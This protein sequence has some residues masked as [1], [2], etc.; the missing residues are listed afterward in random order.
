MSRIRPIP[1]ER[2]GGYNFLQYA[3][4]FNTIHLS[5]QIDASKLVEYRNEKSE[6][7]IS[8]TACLIYTIS[9]VLADFPELNIA[10][11]Y[12]KFFPKIIQYNSINAKFT[13]DKTINGERIVIS[14]IVKD[15]DKK[16]LEEIQHI[17]DQ[18]KYS[19]YSSSPIFKNNRLISSLPVFVGRI[20][21]FISLNNLRKRH[22]IQGSFMITSFGNNDIY[23]IAPL[24]SSSI[25]FSIGII[26]KMPVVI[27]DKILIRDIL[28]LSMSFDHVAFDGA[29]A[30]E[31]L[32]TV[33]NKIENF[34]YFL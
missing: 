21:C 3:K 7:K 16:S 18:Y 13:L 24:T 5:T 9:R 11:K 1:R 32:K 6:K 17:I 29:I 25:C 28:N 4:R 34:N 15:S 20:I 27:D 8:Y 30:S 23:T 12:S 2:R 10:V 33:K 19:D 31:F 22:E 14:C 26:K